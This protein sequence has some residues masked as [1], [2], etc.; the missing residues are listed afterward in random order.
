MACRVVSA[1]SGSVSVHTSLWEA[2]VSY[3]AHGWSILP[4]AMWDGRRFTR[5]HVDTPVDDLCPV[6]PTAS[7]TRDA[8]RVAGL[9]RIAP[10]SITA[11]VGAAFEVLCAP[12]EVA[13]RVLQMPAFRRRP[14]PVLWSPGGTRFLLQPGIATVTGKYTNLTEPPADPGWLAGIVWAAPGALLPL[15]PTPLPGGQARWWTSPCDANHQLGDLHHMQLLV[16]AA[17]DADREIERAPTQDP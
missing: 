7:T 5:G 8:R 17:L 2:A 16:R 12:S 9:W 6:F 1:V 15:P 11:P 13:C 4:A 3:V 14:C 10:Y